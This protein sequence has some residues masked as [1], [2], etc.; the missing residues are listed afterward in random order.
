MRQCAI[1]L[2][3]PCLALTSHSPAAK[4]DV[5]Y[6][7]DPRYLVPFSHLFFSPLGTA[8]AL[9]FIN[10]IMRS[11]SP[12]F[13]DVIG[14]RNDTNHNETTSIFELVC[15][16]NGSSLPIA[17]I[18]IQP[19]RFEASARELIQFHLAAEYSRQL[20]G[21]DWNQRIPQYKYLI[22]VLSI[23]VSQFE[24]GR[25]DR[26]LKHSKMLDTWS[27]EHFY[28]GFG[29]TSLYLDKCTERVSR[30]SDVILND[31]DKWCHFFLFGGSYRV[32]EVPTWAKGD[33]IMELAYW[34]LDPS[35]YTEDELKLQ[36]E[37][38][39]AAET[40]YAEYRKAVEQGKWKFDK[41]K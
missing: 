29:I 40:D 9:R 6:N 20:Q 2:I 28:T 39:K 4:K 26:L 15:L 11:E 24:A 18:G 35:K 19:V 10:D 16:R 13:C 5:A 25:I 34:M 12:K 41:L 17:L 27:H 30:D 21:L 1:F 37:S 33:R 3:L 7:L 36:D 38:I 31:L 14:Y 23:I 22:P 8:I 32:G